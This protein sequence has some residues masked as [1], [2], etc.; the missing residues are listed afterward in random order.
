MCVFGPEQ[1][2]YPRAGKVLDN[3]DILAAAVIAFAGVAFRILVCHN[4]AG[5]FEHGRADEV[6]EAISSSFVFCRWSSFLIA[7]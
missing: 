2:F 5:G 3:I 1:F 6:S 7:E 4:A